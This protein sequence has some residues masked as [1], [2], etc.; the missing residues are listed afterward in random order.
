Y[1]CDRVVINTKRLVS[2]EEGFHSAKNDWLPVGITV[3]VYENNELVQAWAGSEEAVSAY[4]TEGKR[5]WSWKY[6]NGDRHRSTIKVVEG[7]VRLTM[8][9][10]SAGSETWRDWYSTPTTEVTLE[11]WT[12][13]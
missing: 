1:L 8:K 10:K 9:E 5:T 12:V 3:K 11:E 7:R 6:P 4:A 2:I 13:V